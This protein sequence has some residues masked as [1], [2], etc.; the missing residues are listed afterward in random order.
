MKKMEKRK[1]K[2]QHEKSVIRQNHNMRECN[3]KNLQ[4]G[5]NTT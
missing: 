5:N 4:H 1:K 3:M 2:I